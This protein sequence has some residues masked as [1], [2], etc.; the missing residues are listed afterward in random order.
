MHDDNDD[1]FEAPKPWSFEALPVLSPALVHT[2]VAIFE[3]CF[4]VV[5]GRQL[6]L[7]LHAYTAADCDLF[8]A[9]LIYNLALTYHYCG[10]ICA[11]KPTFQKDA[12]NLYVK[13]SNIIGNIDS[14]SN[15]GHAIYMAVSNNA[16]SLALTL[17]NG[18]MCRGYLACLQKLLQEKSD[19][20]ATF[21]HKNMSLSMQTTMATSQ[22]A[23][24]H[25]TPVQ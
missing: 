11:N 5:P 22:A 7:Q 14:D 23:A 13:A 21:F 10:I 17:D 4:V 3:H 12:L 20:Y 9:A 19:F 6:Q 25:D 8:T 24:V 15:D 18:T 1:A 16:A 2:E